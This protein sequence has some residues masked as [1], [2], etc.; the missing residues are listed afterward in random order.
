[1]A[2]S[3]FRNSKVIYVHRRVEDIF[4]LIFYQRLLWDSNVCAP[5]ALL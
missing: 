1:M 4:A 2:F 3:V 5:D